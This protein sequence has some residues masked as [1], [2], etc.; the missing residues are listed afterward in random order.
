MLRR[1][2]LA[3]LLVYVTLDLSLPAMPGAFVFDVDESVESTHPGR[4]RTVAA[5]P[6]AAAP[7]PVTVAVTASAP[8]VT[9]RRR[10][11]GI[12]LGIT[13]RPHP[14][15]RAALARAPGSTA[16]SEDPH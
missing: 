7:G 4:G 13:P 11:A 8:D 2:L 9:P 16:R 5:V 10:R 15:P 3:A 1:A 6:S 14:L 12:A